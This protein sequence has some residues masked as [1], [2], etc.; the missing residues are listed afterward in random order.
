MIQEK[1]KTT[2]SHQKSYTHARRM[3]FE[4]VVDDW[5]YSK[6]SPMKGIMRFGKKEKLS[7]RYIGLYKISKRVG[8]VSYEFELPQ[9]LVEVH[10]VFYISMLKKLLVILH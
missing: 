3:S 9:E 5:A 1:M 2:Q 7:T 10:R 4:F 8:N 6:V